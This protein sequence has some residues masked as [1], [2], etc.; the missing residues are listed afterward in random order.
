MPTRTW[1]P[2]TALV[3][4]ALVANDQAKY[5][6][7]LLQVA[8]EHADQPELAAADLKQE[9]LAS[10]VADVELDTVVA[11]SRKEGPDAYLI[12]AARRIHG[13]LEDDVRRMLTPLCSC[14]LACW[15]VDS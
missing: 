1:L 10:G 7:A 2:V 14:G 15:P 4:A 8:R 3:N 6:M 13:L 12:P 5:L 11:R 9:R